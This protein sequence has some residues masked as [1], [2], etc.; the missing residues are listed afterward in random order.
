MLTRILLMYITIDEIKIDL[1]NLVVFL[2]III[3]SFLNF[4]INCK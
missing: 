3:E 2:K 4:N 1:M